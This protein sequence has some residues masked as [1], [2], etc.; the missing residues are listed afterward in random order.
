MSA[1]KYWILLFA[2]TAICAVG[3]SFASAHG[4]ATPETAKL[5]WGE[6]FALILTLWVRLDR[7]VRSFKVHYEFDTFVF[8]AWPF[9]VPYYLYRSR[10][11]RG[12]LVTAGIFGLY[13]APLIS[14]EVFRSTLV[15]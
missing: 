2:L 12:L 14:A 8:F 7:L 5:L 10:G 4:S 9:L 11:R 3:F 13:L 6:E 15:R 1:S